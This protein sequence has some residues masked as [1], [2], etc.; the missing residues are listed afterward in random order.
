MSSST[1]TTITSKQ[2]ELKSRPDGT[3]SEDNFSVKTVEL[4]PIAAG[5]ILVRNQWM[6]VDPY[7]RGRMKEGKSY[8]PALK[9]GEPLEGGCI[10]EVIESESDLFTEG[11]LVLGKLGWRECWKSSGDGIQKIDPEEAPN[12]AY[13]GVLG[14]TGMTAWV[15][16]KRIENLSPGTTVF[17]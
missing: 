9:L 11:D 12:Q 6:S 4:S 15:G 1:A 7:M 8:V 17:V 10:G 13:L 14:M 2:V 16:L 5:E 3:P